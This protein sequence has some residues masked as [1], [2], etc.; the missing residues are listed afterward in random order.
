[1]LFGSLN[2]EKKLDI[3]SLAINANSLSVVQ[4]LPFFAMLK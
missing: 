3:A 4:M 1:M 2:M